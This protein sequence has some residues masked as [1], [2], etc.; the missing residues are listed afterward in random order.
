MAEEKKDEQLS[1]EELLQTLTAGNMDSPAAI[2]S[3]S[4]YLSCQEL[5][6]GR[7][8]YDKTALAN[9]WKD[10]N[11][12]Q[13]Q[14][15]WQQVLGKKATDVASMQQQRKIPLSVMLLALEIYPALR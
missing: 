7:Q 3:D 6:A 10:R 13:S 15:S 5:V 2:V 11:Q 1:S 8:Q 9:T 14:K 12:A 4:M